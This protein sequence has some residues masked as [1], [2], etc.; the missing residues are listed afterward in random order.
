MMRISVIVVIVA[1]LVPLAFVSFAGAAPLHK[2]SSPWLT[3]YPGAK[4]EARSATETSF[5]TVAKPEELIA[6]YRKL[7][8]AAGMP[9]IPNFDGIGT[10]IRAATPDCDLLINIREEDAGSFAKVDCPV[11]AAGSASPLYGTDVGIASSDPPPASAP[12]KSAAAAADDHEQKA[13]P[14]AAEPEQEP[15]KQVRN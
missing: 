11:R 5:T 1:V 12:E 14:P 7:I 3:P 10:S 8:T 4:V 9:F 6:H 2:A 13:P 15:K